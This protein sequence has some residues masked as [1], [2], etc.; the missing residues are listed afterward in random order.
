M[1]A[2]RIFFVLAHFQAK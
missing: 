1:I 2:D